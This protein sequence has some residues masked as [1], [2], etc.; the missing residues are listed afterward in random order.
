MWSPFSWFGSIQSDTTLDWSRTHDLVEYFFWQVGWKVRIVL[1][2][3]NIS[4][5]KFS[6]II[7]HNCRR[8]RYTDYNDLSFASFSAMTFLLVLN[9][10]PSNNLRSEDCKKSLGVRSGEYCGCGSPI[11]AILPLICTITDVSQF[12]SVF[13]A[14]CF[15]FHLFSITLFIQLA[16]FWINFD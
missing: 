12:S 1:T 16:L 14:I 5:V 7:Q 2:R 9:F 8:R 11:N 13:V 10:F 15:L 6:F 3:N 4:L